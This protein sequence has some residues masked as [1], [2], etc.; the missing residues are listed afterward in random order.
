MVNPLE[1]QLKRLTEVDPDWDLCA[2]HNGKPLVA[3]CY[4][5]GSFPELWLGRGGQL[6]G[7]EALWFMVS[8][9][10]AAWAGLIHVD[11]SNFKAA[12]ALRPLM[13]AYGQDFT[14]ELILSTYIEWK[15]A[16][17]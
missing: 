1:H 15:E 8:E 12:D 4:R 6:Q 3:T 16:T 10:Q 14:P 5:V 7:G 11:L 9:M 13:R 17:K 2:N